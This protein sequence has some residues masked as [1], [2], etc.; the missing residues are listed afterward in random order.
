M[1][2]L[3]LSGTKQRCWRGNVLDVDFEMPCSE[4]E[5]KEKIKTFCEKM[6]LEYEEPAWRLVSYWG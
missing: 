2:Y 3:A 6:G 4:E 5:A 1:M